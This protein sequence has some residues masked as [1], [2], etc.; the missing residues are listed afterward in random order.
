MQRE[1]RK[2]KRGSLRFFENPI[3]S[4]TA[5]SSLRRRRRV[6]LDSIRVNSECRQSVFA[7]LLFPNTITVTE[8]TLETPH[9]TDDA[10]PSSSTSQRRQPLRPGALDPAAGQ[11]AL[12]LGAGVLAQL[13]AEDVRHVLERGGLVGGRD[14]EPDE[15]EGE[16]VE[17]GEDAEEAAVAP[18]DAE[19]DEEGEEAGA[20]EVPEGGPGHADFAAFV[21]ED[22]VER[23]RV[24][25]IVRV[26]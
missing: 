26:L 24:S 4:E 10:G 22:L 25:H 5:F 23:D 8:P 6:R 14:E 3:K 16:G 11:E 19:G 17:G 13:A 9:G 20:G 21:G 1:G 7:R 18:V 12:G 2:E 15:G